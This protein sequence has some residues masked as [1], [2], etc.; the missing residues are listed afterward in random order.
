MNENGS[1][2]DISNKL[3]NFL[4]KSKILNITPFYTN[5]TDYDKI[6]DLYDDFLA[7]M[8]NPPI[9]STNV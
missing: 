2:S 3:F 9:N 5:D 4:V 8:L 1:Y 7:R 6:V